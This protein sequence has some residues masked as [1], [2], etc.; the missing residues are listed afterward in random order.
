MKLKKKIDDI[1]DKLNKIKDNLDFY[2]EVNQII[3]ANIKNKKYDVLEAK[4]IIN[5]DKTEI[6][7]EIDNVINKNIIFS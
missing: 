6:I 1:V 4:E 5:S 3:N 2:Y 7:R